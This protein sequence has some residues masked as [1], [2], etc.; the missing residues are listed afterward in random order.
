MW[1]ITRVNMAWLFWDLFSVP[2]AYE[3]RG[4]VSRRG[5]RDS[6]DQLF[7][8]DPVRSLVVVSSCGAPVFA[9]GIW[10]VAFDYV[11]KP[12]PLNPT[13]FALFNPS[14]GCKSTIT[15]FT[16]KPLNKTQQKPHK[17][18]NCWVTLSTYSSHSKVNTLTAA[19]YFGQTQ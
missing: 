19:W 15:K 4:W 6:V 9:V 11:N 7:V 5:L 2:L 13:F 12:Q 3:N 14:Q 8:C 16:Y 1:R 10:V 18:K 17:S